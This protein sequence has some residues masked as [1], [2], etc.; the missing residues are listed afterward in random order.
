MLG[1]FACVFYLICDIS[2]IN[3]LPRFPSSIFSVFIISPIIYSHTHFSCT[4]Y[5]SSSAGTSGFTSFSSSRQIVTSDPFLNCI[6]AY[7]LTFCFV[8][9]YI[10]YLY[11]SKL[12]PTPL[13]NS[14]AVCGSWFLCLL[15]C[16]SC[17][18]VCQTVLLLDI[19]A[20]HHQYGSTWFV[21]ISNFMLKHR[22]NLTFS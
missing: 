4:I 5:P 13:K 2:I 1:L 17:I 20:S 16:F 22:N 18:L 10:S 7:R 6:L 21:V 12:K 15:C 11:G 9:R 8:F 3:R 19:V 14:P